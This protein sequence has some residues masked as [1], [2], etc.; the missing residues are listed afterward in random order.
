MPYISARVDGA[1]LLVVCRCLYTLE[2]ALRRRDLIRAHD[3][4]QVLRCEHAVFGENIEERVLREKCLGKVDQIKD[5]LVRRICPIR[6]EFKAVRCLLTLAPLALV[7]LYRGKSRRVG[8][9]FRMGAVRYDE[10]LHILIEAARRPEAVTLIAVYLVECL[11]DLDASA[12]QLDVDEREAIHEYGHVIAVLEI[13]AVLRVLVDDLKEIL[14][15]VG[16]VDEHDVLR[17][18]VVTAKVLYIVLL[19]PARLLLDAVI[20]ICNARIEEA[21]PLVISEFVVIQLLYLAAKIT[22]KRVGVVYLKIF[23]AF[24]RQNADEVS[25]ELCLRLIRAIS[26]SLL[27]HILRAHGGLRQLSDDVVLHAVS[28]LFPFECQQLVAVVLVLLLARLN[29]SGESCREVMTDS[30][31]TVKHIDNALLLCKWG[32]GNF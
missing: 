3:E 22:F 32:N 12:L 7:L 28:R 24:L 25:L 6:C 19:Y 1:H 10:Y 13:A 18:A 4:E 27:A 2:Y 31:E 23:V 9:I 17:R 8:V 26:V 30:I 21:L 15:D 11:F 5:F 29:L 20:R 14:V 16:L